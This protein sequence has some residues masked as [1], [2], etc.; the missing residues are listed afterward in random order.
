MIVKSF[1]DE[2]IT[3]VENLTDNDWTKISDWEKWSVGVTAR[4]VGAG[5]FAISKIPQKEIAV[6]EKRIRNYFKQKDLK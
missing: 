5:H 4:H 3:F 1:A 2:V 6:A